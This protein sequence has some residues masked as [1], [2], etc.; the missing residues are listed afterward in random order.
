MLALVKHNIYGKEKRKH[1][2]LRKETF[3]GGLF[4]NFKMLVNEFLSHQF[5]STWQMKEKRECIQH[6][7]KK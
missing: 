6:P 3:P 1:Q 7:P 5:H 2:P 4:T